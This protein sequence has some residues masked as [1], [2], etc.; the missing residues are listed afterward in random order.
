MC[1]NNLSSFKLRKKDFAN[2]LILLNRNDYLIEDNL[3]EK[4]YEEIKEKISEFKYNIK[5]F[6]LSG[7]FN[8]NNNYLLN[9]FNIN[10][11]LR[12]GLTKLDLSYCSIDNKIFFN[13]FDSNK[14]MLNLKILNLNG[15]LLTDDFFS[16]Y[17]SNQFQTKL[18]KLTNLH[19][20][21]NNFELENINKF[22]EF[23]LI[24]KNLVKLNI[25][26]NPFS[27][28]YSVVFP[29]GITLKNYDLNSENLTDFY[30]LLLKIM[31]KYTINN[32]NDKKKEKTFIMKFDAGSSYNILSNNIEFI[33]KKKVIINKTNEK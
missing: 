6:S 16:T 11:P 9:D 18:E 19:I 31:Q 13:F 7:L 28:K 33:S 2:I 8:L 32:E 17:I 10:S 23:I 21:D 14:G 1:K 12:I 22:Y 15:N 5:F 20:N 27:K 4:Y 26:K 24:N 25:T 3:R 30:H 29:K